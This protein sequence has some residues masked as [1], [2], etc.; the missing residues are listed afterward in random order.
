MSELILPEA[1]VKQEESKIQYIKIS[2]LDSK[3]NFVMGAIV[4]ESG[5]MQIIINTNDE[6]RLWATFHRMQSAIEWVLQ[7]KELKR[8]AESIQVAPKSVLDSFR[9]QDDA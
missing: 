4:D 5:K 6:G 9:G 3:P 2:D 7:Q 8:Q 1:E